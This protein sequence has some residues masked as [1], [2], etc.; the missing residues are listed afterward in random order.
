MHLQADP[1]ASVT[2]IVGILAGWLLHAWYVRISRKTK[3]HN[4]PVI[5][6]SSTGSN[7]SSQA[8][9]SPKMS[10]NHAN[11]AASIATYHDKFEESKASSPQSGPW[12]RLMSPLNIRGPPRSTRITEGMYAH[13]CMYH[14]NLRGSIF[15]HSLHFTRRKRHTFFFSWPL[16]V[17]SMGCLRDAACA[18]VR[19]CMNA[20]T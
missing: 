8:P 6:T 10:W 13:P 4:C 19:A 17:S 3:L 20:C 16:A 1:L 2:G 12:D 15:C 14:E 9:T 7:R 11:T 18:Y 5:R